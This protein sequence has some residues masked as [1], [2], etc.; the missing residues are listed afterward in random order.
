MHMQTLIKLVVA[1]IMSACLL[2][3]AA[4]QED[5]LS[6]INAII[7]DRRATVGVA[8]CLIGGNDTISV[9]GDARLPMLSVFKFHVALAVLNEVDRANLS[10]GQSVAITKADLLPDT[11]SPIRDRYPDVDVSLTVAQLIWYTVA[12]SD[13]NGCDILLRLIG[14]TAVVEEYLR[15]VGMIDVE[16]KATEEQMHSA[17]E[18]QYSNWT[19]PNAAV[20]LLAKFC[21]GNLVSTESREILYAIMANTTTGVERLKGRLPA[22][23]VV[24]HKTGS[25]DTNSQGVTAATNDIGIIAM[26]NGT[27]YVIA[28]FVSDSAEDNQTNESIIAE[29]SQAVWRYYQKEH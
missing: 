27:A 12:Q 9:N 24:A 18:V 19:T 1:T 22:G 26:P 21:E 15:G 6:D 4:A 16:I 14:G 11:W 2:N 5:L 10:L 13:N 23:T 20:R 8:S 3:T 25:S 29:I 28:V 7:K 17:W